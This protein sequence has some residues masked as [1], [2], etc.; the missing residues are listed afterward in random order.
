MTSSNGN[1]VRVTGPLC[2]EFIGYRWIPLTKPM[3]RCYDVF[4]D[5]RLN[6]RLS[7]H[8]YVGN[9]RRSRTHYCATVMDRGLLVNMVNFNPSMNRSQHF[10]SAAVG[11]WKWTNNSK[12]TFCWACDYLA[13]LGVIF[14]Y[15]C[16][17]NPYSKSLYK[18]SCGQITP[19]MPIQYKQ[20]TDETP[21]I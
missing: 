20:H 11:V 10:I 16:K 14:R 7:K 4:F 2:W 21:Y 3:T 15:V 17:T 9:C 18:H 5:L 6:K 19:I 1:I 8:R 12:P 13:M